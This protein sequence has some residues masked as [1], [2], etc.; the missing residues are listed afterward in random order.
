MNEMQK[1]EIT[2]T[3]FRTMPRQEMRAAEDGRVEVAFSSETEVD[4]GWYIE[5]LKHDR[6]AVDMERAANGLSFLVNHDVDQLA[7][8]AEDIQIGDDKVA[9]AKVRFG[10]SEFAQQIKR[11]IVDDKIRPDISVGYQ[12]LDYVEEKRDGR[13]YV[14][15]TRWM[16]LEISSVPVPADAAVGVGRALDLNNNN[17]GTEQEN[18]APVAAN[19][20]AV[21]AKPNSEAPGS[22][23]GTQIE[24]PPPTSQ[25]VEAQRGITPEHIALVEEHGLPVTQL[26]EWADKNVSADAAR[27]EVL[28]KYRN[29]KKPL[30]QPSAEQVALT[31]REQKGYSLLRGINAI[32]GIAEGRRESC[33]E[34]EVSDE[35]SKKWKGERKGGLLVPFGMRAG[36][37]SKTAGAGTELKYVE[38]G[39]F[40]EL[41]RNKALV[42]AL[43]AQV[44]TGLQGNIAFP[45]QTGAAQASWVG[46]N[47]GVD[48][49]DTKLA[50]GQMVIS[51]KTLLAST[52]YSRQLL[53]QGVVDVDNMVRADL[54]EVIALAL[55][56]AAIVGKGSSGE[57]TGVLN[58]AGINAYTLKN[59]TGNGAQPVW[60][61]VVLMQKLIEVANARIGDLAFLTTPG[62]KARLKLTARLGNTVALPIWAD[63][64]TI[65]GI[66]A[67]S[68]NQ[69]P[70][71]LTMGTSVGNVH[72]IVLGV[73][74]QMILGMWGPGFELI[75]DPFRLKK[76]GMIELTTI[77]FADVGIRQPG[78]FTKVV[79]ALS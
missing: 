4:L 13:L 19:K 22:G 38:P 73:W 49:A 46:E 9:R 32:I 8:R 14:I 51:P 12:I 63:D 79:G 26:R 11:D 44:I 59:D 18:S 40:I 21:M 55:D 60:D 77:S 37:D 54:A 69:V 45:K 52:S 70:A 28:N 66:R 25:Q 58:Y 30:P 43:G 39:P 56:L 1:R 68:T 24:T 76:Q 17:R 42:K 29:G 75:V 34:L 33:F 41:L 71:N 53:A 31:E 23:A 74:A 3:R 50:T 7:G 35:I 57:P 27:V 78:A 72:A 67:E 47:P 36:L 48:V 15:A 10:S 2:K 62:I 61:D 65:D 16:P 64:G 6:S 20:E 5:V